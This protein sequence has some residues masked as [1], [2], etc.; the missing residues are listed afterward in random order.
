MVV[1]SLVGS[2]FLEG[3]SRSAEP[4]NPRGGDVIR[5][6]REGVGTGDWGYYTTRSIYEFSNRRRYIT[7]GKRI[8]FRVENPFLSESSRRN[9]AAVSVSFYPDGFPNAGASPVL[10]VPPLSGGVKDRGRAV[11]LSEVELLN[12]PDI[13]PA[14][15]YSWA[16]LAKGP[17]RE[18]CGFRVYDLSKFRNEEPPSLRVIDRVTSPLIANKYLSSVAFARY[19]DGKITDM[20]GCSDLFPT[21]EAE[22]SYRGWPSSIIFSRDMVCDYN[23][24]KQKLF[25]F[26]DSV[27]V[28]E[29]AR[30]PG[31]AESRWTSE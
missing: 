20:L 17:L 29:T 6:T 4:E 5:L 12:D 30:S 11:G 27:L 7:T 22:T 9:G 3:C 24:L 26:M 14:I 28:E 25:D 31:Y 15:P 13:I 16:I 19:K 1:L 8:R 10:L 21:C 2:L 23:N 18:H